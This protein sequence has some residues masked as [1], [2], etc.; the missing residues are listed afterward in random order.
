MATDDRWDDEPD[1]D[2]DRGRRRPNPDRARGRLA[3]PAMLLLLFGLFGVFVEVASLGAAAANPDALGNLVAVW[4]RDLADDLPAD[5]KA[6]A[7]ADIEEMKAGLRLDDPLNVGSSA[8]GLVLSLLMVIGA[9]KMRSLTG[10][11]LAMTGAI[12]AIIPMNGC[13]CLA[14]PVGVWALAVLM[15]PDVKA[16]FAAT[17]RRANRDTLD[18]E[19]DRWN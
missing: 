19:D 13:C 10:H 2:R 4:M 12:A 1:A 18:D 6:E 5:E 14:M 11:G 8:L 7:E 16:A 15:S 9:G 3:T 17:A